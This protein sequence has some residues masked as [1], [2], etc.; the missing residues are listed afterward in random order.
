MPE[1]EAPRPHDRGI[2]SKRLRRHSRNPAKQTSV[3]SDHSSSTSRSGLSAKQGKRRRRPRRRPRNKPAQTAVKA[4]VALS[5]PKIQTRGNYA[6]ID[7]QNVNLAIRDQGWNLDWARFRQ[8]LKDKFKITEAFMFIGYVTG[9]EML[10][11][12]LQKAG[13]ILIFK[14]TLEFKKGKEVITKGNVDAELVLHAMIQW[15]N[16]D[17][18]M[19]ASGDGDFHC[20]IEYLEEQN[21]LLHV[22][23]P[24][25][26]KFS[27]LLRRFRKHF[28]YLTPLRKKLAYTKKPA[29]QSKRGSNLRTEP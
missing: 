17:K 24:N 28:V 14:P 11:T 10:Y 9:N 6:F 21:K 5:K 1:T 12:S 26:K 7:S 4:A 16:Y 15:N 25:D 29:V 22:L 8:Y 19:I 13:F 2:P 18:A 3:R 20:L 23:I 27:A